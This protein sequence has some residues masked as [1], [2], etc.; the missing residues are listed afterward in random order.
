VITL[1]DRQPF[2]EG[3]N[4]WCFVHP[5]DPNLCLKVLKPGSL[6]R[7]YRTAKWH[8]RIRGREALDDNLREANAYRQDAIVRGSERVWEHLARW[9]GQID[10]DLGTANVTQLVGAEPG[11]PGPTLETLLKNEGL[12]PRVRTALDAL[13]QWLRETGILT[14]NLLPH[15]LV[16]VEQPED[17][18][19]MII[20]GLGAPLAAQL[21]SGSARLR[22]RYIERRIRRMW[23]RVNWE[24][25]GRSGRWE[26]VEQADR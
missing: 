15:N 6:A 24:A 16:A 19:L 7:Q 23:L 17:L 1:K 2:A 5:D 4:R 25:G 20:D 21:T 26:D 18:K 3:D 10:T 11:R 22:R 14:R 8:K 13:A 9:H 12:S